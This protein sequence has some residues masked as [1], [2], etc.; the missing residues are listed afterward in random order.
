VDSY[1]QNPL[2]KFPRK[3]PVDG[4][5]AN[6]LATSRCN[7]IWE[8]TRHNKHNG[9]T[10]YRLFADLLRGSRQLATALLRGNSLADPGGHME[11]WPP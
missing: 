7:G 10:S 4:E 9:Q 2:R 1:A 3:F 11:S 8:T 5:V 6:F